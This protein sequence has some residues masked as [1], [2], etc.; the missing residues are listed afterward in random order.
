VE[1]V[2]NIGGHYS[3]TLRLWKEKFLE[4]FEPRIRP[5]LQEEHPEMSEEEMEVFKNKWEVSENIHSGSAK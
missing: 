2:E 1:N 3:K 5:A 4:N